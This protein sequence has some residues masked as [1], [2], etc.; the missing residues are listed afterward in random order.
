MQVGCIR[1][2]AQDSIE[3]DVITPD[4]TFHFPHSTGCGPKVGP[5][6]AIKG[7]ASKKVETPKIEKKPT[8]EF[9]EEKIIAKASKEYSSKSLK[10]EAKKLKKTLNK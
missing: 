10:K 6:K 4:F 3:G 2:G 1:C 5:I 8:D 9:K 7:V